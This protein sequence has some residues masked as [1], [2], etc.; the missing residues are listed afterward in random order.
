MST[1]SLANIESKAANTP[2]VIKDSNGTEVGQFCRAWVNF[3]SGTDPINDSFN[4]ASITDVSAGIRT[5]TFTT[6]MSNAN[7]CVVTDVHSSQ[8]NR[9]QYS[10][11]GGSSQNNPSTTSFD[12]VTQ[13][14]TN[15]SAYDGEITF[16]AVF[17]G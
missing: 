8:A 3:S 4:I 5:V 13:G 14:S 11:L 10:M 2:P 1:L 12:V 17:G 15:N 9:N 7:Y 16:V 6:A